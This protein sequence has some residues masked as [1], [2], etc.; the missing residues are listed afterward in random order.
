[1][2]Q[3]YPLYE[4][5]VRRGSRARWFWRAGA[6][7]YSGGLLGIGLVLL[8]WPIA[9]YFKLGRTG[10]A[11]AAAIVAMG[12]LVVLGSF[13][14]KVS[15]GIALDEGIDITAYFEKPPAGDKKPGA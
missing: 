13:L 10:I 15:Y 7:L 8:V 4:E 6:W 14:R 2:L 9:I 5:M 1:M 3:D 12:L 11:Y